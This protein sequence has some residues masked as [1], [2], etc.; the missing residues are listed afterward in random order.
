MVIETIFF[1]EIRFKVLGKTMICNMPC[2]HDEFLYLKTWDVTEKHSKW[3]S[4]CLS[5]NSKI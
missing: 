5:W 1:E 4:A 2:M 3:F